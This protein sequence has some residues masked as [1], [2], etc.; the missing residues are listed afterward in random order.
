MSHSIIEPEQKNKYHT[1]DFK[2][3]IQNKEGKMNY[4]KLFLIAMAALFMQACAP[5]TYNIKQPEPSKIAYKAVEDKG[6]VKLVINDARPGHEKIFSHGVLNAELLMDNTPVEPIAFLKK[7]TQAELFARNMQIELAEQGLAIDIKKFTVKNHRTNAYTPFITMTM[8]SADVNTD[9]GKKRIGIFI[10]RG[11]TP[12]WSFQEIVEPTLNQPL[13]LVVKEFVAKLNKLLLNQSASDLKVKELVAKLSESNVN[14]GTYLDVYQLGFTNNELAIEPLKEFA[15]H[16]DEYVRLAAISGLGTL[17]AES[18]VP[19]LK[20]IYSNA[21]TWQDRA[22][23]LKS[24]GDIG[25]E[26]ARAFIKQ[27]ESELHQKDNKERVWSSE[28]INLYK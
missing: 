19:L 18:A 2:Q 13:G 27:V 4:K 22:M 6:K 15:K 25:T 10:K 7:S 11:K 8:L 21:K 5:M 14:D 17:Q 3:N 28:I 1:A 24:L 9:E 16:D 26:E 23:V 12:I 20:D